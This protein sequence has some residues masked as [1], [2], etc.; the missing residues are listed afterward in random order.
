[1]SFIPST[2]RK[3]KTIAQTLQLNLL[4]TAGAVKSTAL[5]KVVQ[6]VAQSPELDNHSQLDKYVQLDWEDSKFHGVKGKVVKC[7]STEVE[8]LV[9]GVAYNLYFPI[10]RVRFLE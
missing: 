2:R 5:E 10:E 3:V 7:T 8:L 9:E 6:P 1:M 4:D